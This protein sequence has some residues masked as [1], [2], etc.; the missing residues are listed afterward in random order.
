MRDSG[1]SF[2]YIEAELGIGHQTCRRR[3]QRLTKDYWFELSFAVS[4]SGTRLNS[5]DSKGGKGHYFYS[6][7]EV[8]R[9][10]E[11]GSTYN[12][13]FMHARFRGFGVGEH[14]I[15]MYLEEADWFGAHFN[16]MRNLI[17]W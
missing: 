1:K 17:F 13:R 4:D 2:K 7:W 14:M 3:Y 10:F 8:G 12:F 5:A 16:R 11:V 9:G 15:V 6:N